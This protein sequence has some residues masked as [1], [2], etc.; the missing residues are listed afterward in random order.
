[1][2]I[3]EAHKLNAG[4]GKIQVLYDIDF[5]IDK[6][7][8]VVI[9][10]PNGSGKSTFLKTLIGLTDVYSGEIV[11]NGENITRLPAHERVRKG[12]MYIRQLRNV[13]TNLTIEENLRIASYLLDKETYKERVDKILTDFPILKRYL[14]RKVRTLSGGERQILAIAMALITNPVVMMLDEPT[15]HLSPKYASETFKKILEIRDSYDLTIILVEQ[16]VKEALKIGDRAYLLVSGRVK[17]QGE[18]RDLLNNP[19]FGKLYLGIKT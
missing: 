7:E 12:L 3:L 9:V 4:Y 16:V 8:I 10:G 15:A 13:F 18:A 2:S 17:Y 6:K 11:F 19:E 1:M 5:Y 14:R